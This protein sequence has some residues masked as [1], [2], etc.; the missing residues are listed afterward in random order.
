[1]LLNKK[2]FTLVELVVVI[3]ILAILAAIAIPLV[4][5][6]LNSA[7]LNSAYAN[8]RTIGKSIDSARADIAAKNKETYG[9]NVSNVTVGQVI[10][11]NSLQSACEEVT[12]KDRN[13]I[14]VWNSDNGKVVVVYS[15]DFKEVKSGELIDNR[16]SLDETEATL[17]KNLPES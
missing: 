12:Y 13:V 2:G 7:S 5:N 15:D 4:S 6:I 16:V 11:E 17:V 10:K 3:A 1:M 14:P 9:S 8:A